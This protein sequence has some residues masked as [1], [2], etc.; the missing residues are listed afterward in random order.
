LR[1]VGL[2]QDVNC[3]NASDGWTLAHTASFCGR[4]DCLQLLAKHNA[5][6]DSVDYDGNTPGV[7]AHRIFLCSGF[8]FLFVLLFSSAFLVMSDLRS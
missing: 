1:F 5:A 6:L 8:S 3:V 7:C 4:L 2:F